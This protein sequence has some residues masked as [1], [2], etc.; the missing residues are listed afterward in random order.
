MNGRYESR[1]SIDISKRG[2][3][4]GWG[5]GSMKT[6]RKEYEIAAMATEVTGK[7]LLLMASSP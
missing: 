5:Q 6:R 1:R 7:G 4:K 3:T 2:S